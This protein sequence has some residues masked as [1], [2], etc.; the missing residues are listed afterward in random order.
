MSRRAVILA[1]GDLD[2][3][4]SAIMLLRCLPED[5]SVVI[6]NVRSLGEEL[7]RLAEMSHRPQNIYVADIPVNDRTADQVEF[8][9]RRLHELGVE[10]HVYDHHS[11]WDAHK[12]RGRFAACCARFIVDAE[13][14]TAAALVWKH[15][16]DASPDARRWLELLS[17]K[18]GSDDPAVREHFGVLAALMQRR[19]WEMTSAA[20]KVLATGTPLSGS[21]K[22]LAD[23]YYEEHIPRARYLTESAEILTTLRDRK[24]AWFDLRAERDSFFLAKLAAEIHGVSLTAQA[25]YNGV[26]LGGESIDRGIDLGALHGEHE[27]AGIRFSIAGHRSPVK[28]SPVGGR[29]TDSFV[30]AVREFILAEL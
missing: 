1:H 7:R 11:S 14:T 27:R 13:R 15:Y 16:L 12:L 24:L 20:L 21:Q 30:A 22:G 8:H 4:V 28:F 19:H 26:V 9:V 6:A 23:W 3:M 29:A 17:K 25:I 10:I 5:T 2:G 18:D